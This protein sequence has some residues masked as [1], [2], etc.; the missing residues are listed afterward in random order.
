MSVTVC[1]ILIHERP[2]LHVITVLRLHP[3]EVLKDVPLLLLRANHILKLVLVLRLRMPG[4][5]HLKPAPLHDRPINRL[6]KG[7]PLDF[8]RAVLRRSQ[9]VARVPIQQGYY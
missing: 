9:S 1:Q 5:R 2:A 7:V 6:E 3:A 4:R 8:L